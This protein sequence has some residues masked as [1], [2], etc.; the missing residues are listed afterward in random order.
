MNSQLA[1]P[2]FGRVLAGVALVCLAAAPPAFAEACFTAEETRQ[3]TQS[4]DLARLPDIVARLQD[5]GRAELVSARL[6]EVSGSLVYM[7]ALLGRDG[8]L[9]RVTVDARSGNVMHR[10]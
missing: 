3:H 1:L 6:C 9:H 10:R 7:I 8:K 2:L 4:Q 5:R